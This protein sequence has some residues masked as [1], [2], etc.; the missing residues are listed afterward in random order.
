M[1]AAGVDAGAMDQG[2]VHTGLG[3]G[4]AMCNGYAVGLGLIDRRGGSEA[5]LVGRDGAETG[6]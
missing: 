3:A 2:V 4:A 5:H 1:S 6:T